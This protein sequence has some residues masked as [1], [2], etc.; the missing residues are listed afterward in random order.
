MT[1]TTLCVRNASTIAATGSCGT[2]GGAGRSACPPT[3]SANAADRM[4]FMQGLSSSDARAGG[5]DGATSSCSQRVMVDGQHQGNHEAAGNDG[6]S[7]DHD[8]GPGPDQREHR[9]RLQVRRID[10]FR[11]QF[12]HIVLLIFDLATSP[13]L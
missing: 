12:C 13:Y 10:V 5:S 8:I 4:I 3:A 6:Q 7:T 1:A 11:C 9:Q 2:A